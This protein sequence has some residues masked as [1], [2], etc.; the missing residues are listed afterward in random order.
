MSIAINEPVSGSSQ[1]V[2]WCRLLAAVM[3]A[4]LIGYSALL[5]PLLNFKLAQG[6][7]YGGVVVGDEGKSRT[8]TRVLMPG[9]L[10]L[11]LG[12]AFATGPALNRN[13]RTLLLA[14]ASF[15]LLAALSAVWSRSASTTLNLAV[16]QAILY[17]S[18]G[19]FVVTANNP[20]LIVRSTLVMF[21]AVVGANLV[22]LA[23]FP[24][25]E[26][27]H[28]GI[29]PHKNTLGVAAGSAFLFGLFCL[30]EGRLFLRSTALFAVL[31]SAAIVLA[32]SSKT[33]FAL[34]FVA[35]MIAF[36]LFTVWRTLR[37]GP[38]PGALLATM[39]MASLF[40][41]GSSAFG[42][43]T[44]DVLVVIYGDA[45]FT[46]RTEIWGFAMDY[47]REA[48]LF[49]NGYRGF[50]GLG[51]AA[52]KHGS[53][54]EFIRTIGSAHS[55]YVDIL[56]DLGIL[57]LSLLTI[58][59]VLTIALIGKFSLRPTSRSLLYLSVVFFMLGRNAMESVILWSSFFD[60]LTFLLVGFLACY[61]EAGRVRSMSRRSLLR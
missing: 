45:S 7:D 51:T 47:F 19:L 16:Y 38:I 6:F 21:S 12:L 24:A 60:N 1:L 36:G 8:L 42:F 31:G 32:S 22:A 57:G 13:I 56:L 59:V 44:D 37:L 2:R 4:V 53:E 35:P 10:A 49:G 28:A 30:F 58:Y 26:F 27:G 3:P 11:A 20:Q 9:F 5:D 48:P 34:M 18:L 15:L 55:G 46:G 54:I 41:I 17:C 43:T 50:W 52:P 33:A 39:L 14:G 40:V 61:S 23:L 25:G 29:Y